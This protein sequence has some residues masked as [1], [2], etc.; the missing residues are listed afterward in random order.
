MPLQIHDYL[1]CS[2]ERA[3]LERKAQLRR[4]HL[5]FI[6]MVLTMFVVCMGIGAIASLAEVPL[7]I[8][9]IIVILWS[10]WFTRLL[11]NQRPPTPP[12]ACTSVPVRESSV[13]I[14]PKNH[15]EI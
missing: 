12:Q 9:I 10:V 2:A 14:Q 3:A 6:M 7:V 11:F 15:N 13:S 5:N 8:G 1:L 4:S